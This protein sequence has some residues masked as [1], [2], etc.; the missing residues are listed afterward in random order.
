MSAA[1]ESAL[2]NMGKNL[3]TIFLLCY[4]SAYIW[5]SDWIEQMLTYQIVIEGEDGREDEVDREGSEGEGEGGD[6]DGN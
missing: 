1:Q 5:F 6:E 4:I 2:N 3:I